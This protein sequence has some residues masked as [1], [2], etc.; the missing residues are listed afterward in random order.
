MYFLV[1][2]GYIYI[3][4]MHL[5]GCTGQKYSADWQG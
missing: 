5:V 2:K 1:I 4:F 3:L